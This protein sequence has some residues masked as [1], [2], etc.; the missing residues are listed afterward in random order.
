MAGQ[1]HG[2]ELNLGTMK[3]LFFA[4]CAFLLATC[5]RTSNVAA[6]GRGQRWRDPVPS[7]PI[8]GGSVRL[9]TLCL[10][11]R[12]GGR[13]RGGKKEK[14]RTRRLEEDADKVSRGVDTKTEPGDKNI[15]RRTKKKESEDLGLDG[16]VTLWGSGVA[17]AGGGEKTRGAVLAE[18]ASRQRCSAL[19]PSMY[20]VKVFLCLSRFGLASSVRPAFDSPELTDWY[21]T[22]RMSTDGLKPHEPHFEFKVA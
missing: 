7:T 17:G 21:H 20:D 15:A 4:A 16:P 9:P 2:P 18:L 19:D 1:D 8:T 6:P 3:W 13:K 11:L 12:G 14:R 5:S 10:Q 22:I